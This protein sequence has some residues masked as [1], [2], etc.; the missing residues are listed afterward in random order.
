[1]GGV[2]PMDVVMQL[3]TLGE[4]FLKEFPLFWQRTSV[5]GLEPVEADYGVMM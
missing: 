4:P 1:M 3:L 5:L 2:V